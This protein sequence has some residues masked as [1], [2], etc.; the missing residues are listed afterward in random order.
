MLADSSKINK[1]SSVT[2]SDFNDA[3]VITSTVKETSFKKCANVVEADK[4]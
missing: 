2:F 1:I 4:R 3:V